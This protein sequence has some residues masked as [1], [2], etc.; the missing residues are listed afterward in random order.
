MLGD[1]LK[2]HP[3]SSAF[4]LVGETLSRSFYN[5]NW[6]SETRHRAGCDSL[7]WNPRIPVTDSEGIPRVPGQP[8]YRHYEAK[9][10]RWQGRETETE[11][12]R[13]M[14]NTGYTLSRFSLFI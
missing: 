11:I 2:F 3:R 5:I 9:G 6:D 13:E 4:H 1:Y 7:P 12:D 8:G 10:S 14:E